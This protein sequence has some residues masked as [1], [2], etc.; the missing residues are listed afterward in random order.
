M[1]EPEKTK[2]TVIDNRPKPEK[3]EL[4]DWV[5]N[6]EAQR[7]ERIFN[8]SGGWLSNPLYSGKI[9]NDPCVCGSG[10]KV[11]KC[12]GRD[13]IIKDPRLVYSTSERHKLKDS[14]FHEKASSEPS[15]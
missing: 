10:K 8:L 11:K 13:A 3:I 5:K 14:Y 7:G 4:P 6:Q 12:C 1:N 15:A 9:R 2:V